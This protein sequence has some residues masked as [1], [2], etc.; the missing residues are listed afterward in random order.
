MVKILSNL[1]QSGGVESNDIR[2]NQHLEG[3]VDIG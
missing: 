1:L 3:G 2:L